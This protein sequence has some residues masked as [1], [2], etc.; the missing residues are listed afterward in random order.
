MAGMDMILH[1]LRDNHGE[2]VF[3]WAAKNIDYEP[4]DLDGVSVIPFRYD[5]NG[6][7][8]FTHFHQY[9]DSY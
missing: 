9:H 4:R 1:W 5:E 6:K 7:Q 2:E 8:L 3:T